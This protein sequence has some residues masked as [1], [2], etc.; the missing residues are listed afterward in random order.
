MRLLK[1]HLIS[2]RCFR[3]EMNINI[4]LCFFGHTCES[5]QLFCTLSVSFDISFYT[6]RFLDVLSAAG[7]IVDLITLMSF[8]VKRFHGFGCVRML[9][10]VWHLF[11]HNKPNPHPNPSF[12]DPVTSIFTCSATVNPR[13]TQSFI[14][15]AFSPSDTFKRGRGLL[16][17]PS[18]LLKTN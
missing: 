9:T 1:N 5:F 14:Y 15:F 10:S 4:F 2:L 17:V 12:I 11:F 3:K 8:Y 7:G 18:H 13:T 16:C 6:L